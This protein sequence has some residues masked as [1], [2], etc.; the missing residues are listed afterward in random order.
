MSAASPWDELDG[1]CILRS[2]LVSDRR[3]LWDAEVVE[4][5]GGACEEPS[6][7]CCCWYWRMVE[8]GEV[9]VAEEGSRGGVCRELGVRSGRKE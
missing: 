1:L 2:W 6:P 8:D 3:R 9:V 7:A 4:G 5:D